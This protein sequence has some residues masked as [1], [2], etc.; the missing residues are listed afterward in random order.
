MKSLNEYISHV[1]DLH[2]LNEYL[3]EKLLV[4]KN[5]KSPIDSDELFEKLYKFSDELTYYYS[6]SG[7]SYVTAKNLAYT[8]Y[9]YVNKRY[10]NS[11]VD[12]KHIQSYIEDNFLTKIL[13]IADNSDE[14]AMWVQ[15][16]K[17]DPISKESYDIINKIFTEYSSNKN[18]IY[19]ELN[20]ALGTNVKDV[21]LKGCSN[22]EYTLF[23]ICD[24]MTDEIYAF[25]MSKA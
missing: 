2:Y 23:A 20:I 16:E 7:K 17:H 9:L 8:I 6:N 13:D 10:I 25:W 19:D 3:N 11:N 21:V 14:Y 22:N 24:S 5:Y 1:K 4:N 12:V 15:I 18:A